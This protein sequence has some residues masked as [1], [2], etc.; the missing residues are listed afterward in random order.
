[1]AASVGRRPV[2]W[3]ALV[4]ALALAGRATAGDAPTL[5]VGDPAPPL[6][7]SKWLNGDPVKQFEKGKVYVLECWATW[8]GPCRAT[9]P[10]V[11]ELNTK[12]K[13][14]GVVIIGMNVWERDVAK[15]E[16]FVK[17][18]GEKMNYRVALDVPGA[19]GEDSGKTAK[20]W[21]TASGQEGIPCSFVVDKEGM[22]AWIGHPMAG[23]DK[24]IE[25]V[26][27]GTFDAR[28][29]AEQG[30]KLEKAKANLQAALQAQDA[31]KITAALD[32][33]QE[34]DPAA[35]GQVGAIRFQ[36]LIKMKKD[37]KAAYALAA[38]M[39]DKEWKD[40]AMT[41]N[42]LAWM[43]LDEP[44]LKSRDIDLAFRMAARADEL[45]QHENAAILDTFARAHFEKGNVDQAIELQ[46]LAIQKAQDEGE[47]SKLSEVLKRYKAKKAGGG[48]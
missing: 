32:E 48:T 9:I 27:A 6:F 13:A 34:A 1:M 17:Q 43:I 28:K 3:F 42:N 45:A 24:V 8:C 38:R 30:V 41:L 10:H 31:D 36:V 11:S 37:E 33:V 20:A 25:G 39:A 46:T 12:Y 4:A 19:P 47:K 18:M 35:A 2:A 16:P 7:A 26:V 15:V 29:M 14:K 40:E 44:G 22:I 23:L 21:M 5:K